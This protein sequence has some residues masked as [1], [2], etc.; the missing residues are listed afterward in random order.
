MGKYAESIGVWEHAIGNIV[1]RFQPDMLDN[2]RVGKLITH[3]QKTKDQSQM[4]N[5]LCEYYEDLVKRSY[6]E[7]SEEDKTEIG[8][9]IKLNQMQIMEDIM[10]SH[11]WTTKEDL[12]KSKQQGDDAIKNLMTTGN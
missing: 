4:L 6:P 8:Q 9:W 10:V 7:M 2:D 3:Y 1:H 12:V 5:K 11:R